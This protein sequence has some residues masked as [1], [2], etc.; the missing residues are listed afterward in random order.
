MKALYSAGVPVSWSRVMREHRAAL[1]PLGIVFIA[2]LIALVALVLPLSQRVDGAEQRAA[3]AERA[4][5]GA[6]TEFKRAELLR[7]S[8][9]RATTDLE[10][11]YREVLPS[12]V[13]AARRILGLR[14][15]QMADQHGVAYQGSGT[16]E[17]QIRDSTLLRLR[18]SMQLSGGYEDIRDFIYELETSP[19]FVVIDQIRL[20]ESTR[21]SDG[22]QLA[23][24]VSTYYRAPQAALQVANDGR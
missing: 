20:S 4:R 8:N 11:F 13:A 7:T 18:I 16:T 1:W 10:T 12:N 15:R 5:E 6:A 24:D 9:S 21:A 19:D 23:L 14:L 3:T 22:L 17:E 2:N